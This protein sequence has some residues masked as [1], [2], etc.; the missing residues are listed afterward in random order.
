[1]IGIL[2]FGM[3]NLRS[4]WSAVH[5]LGFDPVLI[6]DPGGDLSGISHLIIP[7]VGSFARAMGN[8]RERGLEAL[9]H[10]FA[11]ANKPVLGICL[12]MQLLARDGSEGGDTLGLAL[13]EGRVRLFEQGINL[14]VPHMGWNDLRI[15]RPH[16]VLARIKDRTDYYFVHSYYFES[17]KDE[18]VIATTDYGREFPSVVGR[19]NVIGVQFHPEKSQS[20]GLKILDAFLDWSGG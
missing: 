3:C 15:R 17:F 11:K 5:H 18:D 7:G 13:I 20:N 1:M 2:D 6:K 16:P 19:G 10:D 9:V 12:G 8:I 14:P 4:V